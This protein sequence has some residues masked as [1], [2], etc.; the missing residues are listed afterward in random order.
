[1]AKDNWEFTQNSTE[2]QRWMKN[3]KAMRL[4]KLI[5]YYEEINSA[6]SNLSS[7]IDLR[8]QWGNSHRSSRNNSHPRFL[9]LPAL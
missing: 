3:T 8:T 7:T 6:D 9:H 5:A 4:K 1:M 2:R